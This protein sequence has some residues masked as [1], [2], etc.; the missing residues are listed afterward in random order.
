MNNYI[1]NVFNPKKN[2]T[3][4]ANLTNNTVKHKKQTINTLIFKYKNKQSKNK[5]QKQTYKK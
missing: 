1:N 4:I 2:E 3:R 5:K